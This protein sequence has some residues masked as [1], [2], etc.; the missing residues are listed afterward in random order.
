MTA[1]PRIVEDAKLLDAV[2]Y[3]EICQLAHQGAKVIHPRAVEIAMQ[4]N[5]PV[6]VRSTFS[7]HPGTLVS[8]LGGSN[9]L[10][11]DTAMTAW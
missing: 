6:R 8:N 5:I 10:G 2:T 7:D 11:T 9:E 3:N 4:K 1:D